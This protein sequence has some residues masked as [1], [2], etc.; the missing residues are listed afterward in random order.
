MQVFIASVFENRIARIEDEVGG[1]FEK[2]YNLR[3]LVDGE[4]TE[5]I[6]QVIIESEVVILD[7]IGGFGSPHLWTWMAG[8]AW[9][10]AFGNAVPLVGICSDLA[11]LTASRSMREFPP[12]QE[13]LTVVDSYARLGEVVAVLTNAAEEGI[14]DYLERAAELHVLYQATIKSSY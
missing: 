11:K 7:L 3:M 2:S 13:L 12:L 5:E 8:W 6:A 14:D 1:H 9:G 4:S 10:V